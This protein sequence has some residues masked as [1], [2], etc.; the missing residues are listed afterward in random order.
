MNVKVRITRAKKQLRV[1]LAPHYQH[2][3]SRTRRKNRSAIPQIEKKLSTIR[4]PV[5]THSDEV[6][7]GPDDTSSHG[8][9][10]A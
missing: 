7:F 8:E 10:F 4:K 3:A 2:E 1:L 5:N 9:V 6:A